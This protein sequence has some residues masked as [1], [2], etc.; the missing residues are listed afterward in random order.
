ML[1]YSLYIF[2]TGIIGTI[3]M[4][5]DSKSFLPLLTTV[6]INLHNAKNGIKYLQGSFY[7]WLIALSNSL[8]IQGVILV[9]SLFV[10]P[11]MIVLYST[12]KMI[13]NFTSY[14]GNVF[15]APLWPEFTKLYET[16]KKELNKL[17]FNSINIIM[18]LNIIVPPIHRS[19]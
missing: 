10:E 5:L 19:C 13:G 4:Y 8:N 9:L 11:G 14:I 12:H 15:Q 17:I 2:S 6:H 16:N 1:Y 3:V 7:F 18:F